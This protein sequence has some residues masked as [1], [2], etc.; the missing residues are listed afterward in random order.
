MKNVIIA[1]I[2]LLTIS[3][4]QAAEPQDANSQ[5]IGSRAFFEAHKEILNNYYEDRI[6]EERLSAQAQIRLLEVAEKCYSN[7]ETGLFDWAML[8]EAVIRINDLERQSFGGYPFSYET[9]P[10]YLAEALSQIA[11]RKSQILD[12]MEWQTVRLERIRKYIT[13]KGLENLIKM[14]Q[15]KPVETHGV[16]NGIIYSQDKPVAV[17]DGTAVHPGETIENAKVIQINKDSVEFEKDSSSW[18][19]KVGEKLEEKWK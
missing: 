15:T 19:Q 4:S 14:Q 13:T 5:S 6:L 16:V 2:L 12:D 18:T 17:V 9:A 7:Y 10:D 11:V 3:M 1:A 8:A